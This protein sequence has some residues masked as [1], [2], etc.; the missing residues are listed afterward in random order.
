MRS[1]TR[2]LSASGLA[3]MW[4]ASAWLVSSAHARPPFVNKVPTP[5]SCDTCHDN[6]DMRTWRNGFGIDFASAEA[7][8]ATDDDPGLCDLDSDRDGI[9]NG[10]ELGDPD[11]AWREGDPLPEVM[12]TNPGEVRDPDRC[13]DGLLHPGEDCDGADLAGQSCLDHDF[14]AGELRC[15]ADCQFDTEGCSNPAPDA[16]PP[17]APDAAGPAPDAASIEDSAVGAPDV[18]EADVGQGAGEDAAVEEASSDEGSCAQG[19]GATGPLWW[20]LVLLGVKRRRRSSA[21]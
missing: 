12:A 19:A 3:A 17:A 6:P 14:V 2:A 21:V 13:G 7:V 1:K 5:F 9:R 10:D 20:G 8:W 11:C 4:I 15:T 18:L 16:T